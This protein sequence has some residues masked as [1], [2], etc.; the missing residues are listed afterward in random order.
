MQVT[1]VADHVTHAMIGGAKTIEFGISNDAAFFQILSSTLY[2]NQRLAV[3]RE[4]LCNAWD[5][6][7]RAG[8]TDKPVIV[9]IGE[10]IIVRDFGAGIH[11]DMMGPLYGTYGGSDKKNNGTETGGF[12]LGCKSPFAYGDHF[13]VT[14]WHEGVKTIYNLSKSSADKFGK[15]GITPIVALSTDETGLQVKIPVKSLYDKNTFMELFEQVAFN[16]EMNVMINGSAIEGLPLST[17]EYNWVITN[18]ILSEKTNNV[19]VRYGNVIYPIESNGAYSSQY[20]T[21]TRFLSQLSGRTYGSNYS[22]IFQAKPDTISVTP[23][24]ES[25]SMQEHTINTLKELVSGFFSERLDQQIIKEA[26]PLLEIQIKEIGEKRE[27]GVLMNEKQEMPGFIHSDTR[28]DLPIINN[29]KQLTEQYTR[30]NYPSDPTFHRRD[31]ELRINKAIELGIG[32]RGHLN[33]VKHSIIHPK[34]KKGK[35]SLLFGKERSWYSSSHAHEWFKRSVVRPLVRDIAADHILELNR[36]FIYLGEKSYTG[37]ENMVAPEKLHFG[38][39]SEYLPIMR[40]VMVISYSQKEVMSRL[41]VTDEL[42]SLGGKQQVWF[43]HAPLAKMKIQHIR[44]FFK[45]RG[46]IIFDLTEEAELKKTRA[47]RAPVD[48]NKPKKPVLTGYPSLSGVFVSDKPTRVDNCFLENAPRI[49]KPLF[50]HKIWF[51]KADHRTFDLGIFAGDTARIVAK[52]FGDQCA[53]VRTEPQAKKLKESGLMELNEYVMSY[54]TKTVTTSPTFIAYWAE[55]I[56]RAYGN[57]DGKELDPYDHPQKVNEIFDVLEI[58]KAVGLKHSLNEHDLMVLAIWRQMVKYARTYR[59]SAGSTIE[60]TGRIIKAFPVSQTILDVK[61]KLEGNPFMDLINIEKFRII[62]HQSQ[63]KA[64]GHSNRLAK[65][66]KLAL[67][68]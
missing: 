21:L 39:H 48:P 36:F 57:G 60:D 53:V 20:T 41:T 15:P 10:E 56:N 55:D 7:I 13:E 11:P 19:F 67:L 40:K 50:F 1:H 38:E 47:F 22:I 62:A 51:S 27:V 16:G 59:N 68:G 66:I 42:K 64:N 3:A 46:F 61:Q 29:V 34:S 31:M 58:R 49:K 52:F 24:R 6:H 30:K 45:A 63:A 14:T 9:T 43:Y 2:S 8:I 25:L 12:G 23:S 35:I 4:V 37:S 17:A 28:M 65:I 32:N 5:A 18:K 44:D 33:Q 54:I 26:W